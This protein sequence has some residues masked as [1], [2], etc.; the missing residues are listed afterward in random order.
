MKDS[1]S[2]SS[3]IADLKNLPSLSNEENLRKIDEYI[4]TKDIDVRDEIIEGNLRLVFSIAK[5]NSEKSH[6]PI[7]DLIQE[8]SLGL[9]SAVENFN[10]AL[11]IPFASYAG[12]KIQ[13]AIYDYMTTYSNIISIPRYI[14]R[15]VSQIENKK[16]QLTQSLHRTPTDEEIAEALGDGFTADKIRDTLVL[17]KKTVSIELTNDTDCESSYSMLD[18]LSDGNDP[19]KKYGEKEIAEFY[20]EALDLL[21]ERS[22]DILMSRSLAKENKCTLDELSKKYHVSKERI[23]QIEE[24]SISSVRSYL[25]KRI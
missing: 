5:K 12:T 22:R 20:R 14:F 9:V 4:K 21:D 7:M 1:I 25:L 19:S 13:N 23:R 11:N 2:Y 3:F 8:G 24:E 16:N 10:P 18:T 6:L 17:F 15:K